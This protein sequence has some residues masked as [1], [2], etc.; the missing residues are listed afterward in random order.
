MVKNCI[1]NFVK[2]ILSSF[3]CIINIVV[4]FDIHFK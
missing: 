4:C 2:L 3:F 1:V